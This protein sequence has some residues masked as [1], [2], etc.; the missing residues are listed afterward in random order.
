MK[1]L[2]VILALFL[3]G[4]AFPNRDLPSWG[5]HPATHEPLMMN[6]GHRTIVSADDPVELETPNTLSP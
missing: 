4:C 2:S 1:A 6:L 3:T 5:T